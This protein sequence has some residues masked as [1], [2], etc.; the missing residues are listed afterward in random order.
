MG[1]SPQISP[2]RRSRNVIRD[3]RTALPRSRTVTTSD[4]V[5]LSVRDYGSHAAGHTVVLLHGFC[6]NKDSWNLQ[7]VQLIRRWGSNIRII[8]YDHRG[9][10]D[11]SSAPMHTYRIAQLA[12]DLAGLLVAVGVAGPLTLVGHSMGGMAV[13]AYL[14]RSADNRPVEPDSVV[15]IATAAG[16]LAERG[17]GRLLAIPALG[18]FRQ[19]ASRAPRVG[20]YRAARVL[21]RAT[22]SAP[23][24][25][26]GYGVVTR[27]A[28]LAASAFTINA[29]PLTTKVGFLPGLKAYDQYQTLPLITAKTTVI[30]GGADELIPRSHGRDLAR[31][32][33]AATLIHRRTAGH[34]LLHEIPHV[35]TEAISSAIVADGRVWMPPA[36]TATESTALRV[37]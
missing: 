31:A 32:I 1:T 8:C 36:G 30:S 5:K 17:L 10:G 27:A 19:L 21:A 34:M 25:Y 2:T 29:T 15:L 18:I 35:V 7:I 22:S 12:D 6:L 9:H 4:G 13:L 20:S 3:V 24:G 37:A 28:L 23:A 33:P 16:K 11:S 26:R 14:G